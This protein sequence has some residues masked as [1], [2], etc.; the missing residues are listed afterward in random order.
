MEVQAGSTVRLI[1]PGATIHANGNPT[2]W[3][4][5]MLNADGFWVR[6]PTDAAWRDGATLVYS[7]AGETATRLGD[8]PAR[9]GDVLRES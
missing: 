7:L 9:D 3:P 5:W 1:Y 8:L 4:G 6:D 2:D